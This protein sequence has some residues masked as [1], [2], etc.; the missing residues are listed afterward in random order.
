MR[1]RKSNYH[2]VIVPALDALIGDPDLLKPDLNTKP[3][4]NRMYIPAQYIQR[5]RK[6]RD[7]NTGRGEAAKELLALFA[8]ILGKIHYSSEKFYSCNNGMRIYFVEDDDLDLSAKQID[9]ST[10]N[11]IAVVKYLQR[12]NIKATVLTGDDSTCASAFLNKINVERINPEVY[13]GRRRLKLSPE[14]CDPWFSHR[15]LTR[16]EFERFFPEERPLLFNEFVEFVIDDYAAK[17]CDFARMIGRYEPDPSTG[18]GRGL[19]MLHYIDSL[20]KQLRPRSAG[21]AMLLEALMAPLEEIPIVISPSIFGTGKTYAAIGCG[22]YLVVDH[23][24]QKYEEIFVVPRDAN[25]GEE[26]GFLP[27]DLREKVMPEIGPLLDNIK[28]YLR[29]SQNRENLDIPTIDK[30]VLEILD[31]HVKIMPLRYMGGRSITDS[32]II[33]DEAQDFERFQINQ[34]MKR[35]GERSKMVITGDPL[36]TNNRHM[37]K[38]SNGLSYAATKMAGSPLAAVVSM[39][40]A[41]I[42]RCAAAIEVGRRLG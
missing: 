22:L 4:A 34:L 5:I 26:I 21:Q 32:W 11:T 36:Q 8:M 24:P 37:N 3:V 41:E 38:N 7:E 18:N 27:G 9:S 33:Y 28:S 30:Q 2:P 42:T 35:I 16:R 10:A 29:N 39:T 25:L 17:S 6:F 14:A 20:P 15:C 13:T 40:E 12:D 23:K 31:K 1:S 19:R